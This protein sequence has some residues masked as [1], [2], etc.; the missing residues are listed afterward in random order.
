VD[1]IRTKLQFISV[2]SNAI[3]SFAHH[4]YSLS[5]LDREKMSEYLSKLLKGS[6]RTELKHQNYLSTRICYPPGSCQDTADRHDQ[7]ED[8]TFANVL[9]AAWTYVLARLSATNDVV[10]DSFV[11]GHSQAGSLVH[12]SIPYRSALSLSRIRQLEIS[13]QP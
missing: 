2:V 3:P 8:V 7:L 11:Y 1:S 12:A 5:L 9:K 4:Q 6:S 13:S 10:F